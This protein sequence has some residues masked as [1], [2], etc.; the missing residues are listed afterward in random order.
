[1]ATCGVVDLHEAL[2]TTRAM[3]R[4]KPDAIPDDVQARILDAA[5]RAPSGG[6]AQNWRFLLVDEP[7]IK[8]QLGPLYRES[9]AQLWATAYKDLIASAQ[10]SP[11]SPESIET[12]RIVRS[13]QYLADHFEGVPL[14][15]FAFARNDRSGGSIFPAVWSAMLAARAEGVGSALTSVLGGF[16]AAETLAVLGVPPDHGWV[17]VCCVSFGYP[18]GRWGIAARIPAHQVAFRNRWGTPLG[19]EIPTPLWPDGHPG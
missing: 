11:D 7:A 3:R 4:V 6:N 2:Y 18:T 12:L 1:M 8:G 16:R 14:F 17:N 19:V 10:A 13:A 9:L 15:L 5:I